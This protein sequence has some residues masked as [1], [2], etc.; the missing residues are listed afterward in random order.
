MIMKTI[1]I[2]LTTY[3]QSQY[4]R[5]ALDGIM[6]QRLN[7]DVQMRIIVADDC[8]TDGT[9]DIIKTYAQKHEKEWVFLPSDKNLGI[10]ENYKRAIAATSADYVAIIEG[11]DYWTDAYRLQ[12]HIDYLSTHTD[13]VMTKNNY[14]EY[15]HSGK[16]W[17][18]V[19]SLRQYLLLRNNIHE[20]IL[21]NLSCTIFRGDVLRNVDERVYVYGE[22]Q[23]HEATDYYLTIGVLQAGYGYVL[24]D[25]MS[26]YRVGTGLNV[27]RREM[28]GKEY[29][30]KAYLW[31]QQTLEMLGKPY[32][33]ECDRIYLDTIKW[34]R[35]YYHAEKEKA[36]A[37]YCPPFFAHFVWDWMPKCLH[38]FKTAIRACIPNALHR[39]IKRK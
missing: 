39:K 13:C 21:G 29:I 31:S 10:A 34:V 20:Y 2:L 8:S 3:N 36:W 4:I 1:D 25:A 18:L 14:F 19:T 37:E 23:R 5:Q 15:E 30:A 16:E 12:K 17:R 28:S 6:M 32:E 27:S 11:D 33:D 35:A 26:V 24:G 7:E 9:Q 22:R 38:G